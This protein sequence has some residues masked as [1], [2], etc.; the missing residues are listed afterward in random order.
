MA[1]QTWPMINHDPSGAAIAA[2][3]PSF[4]EANV[5]RITQLWEAPN[6]GASFPGS[7][8]APGLDRVLPPISGTIT[9][10]GTFA[11]FCSFNGFAY[12][13]RIETGELVWSFL[14]GSVIWCAPLICP[15]VVI[16]QDLFSA[17][18]TVYA[19]NRITGV[20][21]WTRPAHPQASAAG[22]NAAPILVDGKVLI[23]TFSIEPWLA[24][25]PDRIG[26]VP[27]VLPPYT[28]LGTFVQGIFALDPDTGEEE[29]H[30]FII[31]S[32]D[33]PDI[34]SPALFGNYPGYPPTI[35][36]AFRGSL[37][38]YPFTSR[39]Q[40]G[41]TI[42]GVPFQIQLERTLLQTT[43]LPAGVSVTVTEL[44]GVAKTQVAGA[45]ANAS[46]FS[47]DATTGLLTFHSTAAG[48]TGLSSTYSYEEV[49]FNIYGPSANDNLGL[50][51]FGFG[52][53]GGAVFGP[54]TFDLKNRLVYVSVGVASA[55][56]VINCDAVMAINIDDGS[57]A[58]VRTI[59]TDAINDV[60]VAPRPWGYP[61]AF[62][63]DNKAKY[64]LHR[65]T[66]GAGPVHQAADVTNVVTAADS[67]TWLTVVALAN[68]QRTQHNAHLA[69]VAAHFA[70]DA[71]NPI[72]VPA[73]VTQAVLAGAGG[74]FAPFLGTEP[75]ADRSF[76]VRFEN[77]IAGSVTVVFTIEATVGACVI[78]INGLITRGLAIANVAQ[79]DLQS[80]LI[81]GES[82][83][84]TFNVG[85][86]VTTRLGIPANGDFSTMRNLF[87]LLE[88]VETNFKAHQL[89]TIAHGIADT[90]PANQLNP[91]VSEMQRRDPVFSVP[92]SLTSTADPTDIRDV[93]A[94]GSR[95]GR[96]YI[97][98]ALTGN[99]LNGA[100]GELYRSKAGWIGG[101][102]ISPAVD[103]LAGDLFCA[104]NSAPQQHR[105][106]PLYGNGFA[107]P[108]QGSLA[109]L[110]LT[111][112][113]VSF[114]SSITWEV[115]FTGL[116]ALGPFTGG[117]QRGQSLTSA[118]N[119]GQMVIVNDLVMHV[120]LLDDHLWIH[121]KSDGTVLR[122][123]P[124]RVGIGGHHGGI[125]FTEDK[126]FVGSGINLGFF[127]ATEWAWEDTPPELANN[128]AKAF[129]FGLASAGTNSVS[130]DGSTAIINTRELSSD[131]GDNPRQWVIMLGED[132]PR[133]GG[134]GGQ[135]AYI[136]QLV[137]TLN[138][139]IAGRQYQAEFDWIRGGTLLVTANDVRVSC[140]R[141]NASASSDEF[142]Q[143]SAEIQEE[144]GTVQARSLVQPQRTLLLAA[145][146]QGTSVP[147][148]TV[149]KFANRIIGVQA[150]LV[151]AADFE[152]Q[153]AR[154]DDVTIVG[155]AAFPDQGDFGR[156]DIPLAIDCTR[157]IG[158]ETANGA[159]DD[160]QNVRV[161]FEL[162]LP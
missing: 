124:M 103:N 74:V 156:T 29:W 88:Q 43:G 54:L 4:T 42:P 91:D 71:V 161:T 55:P 25:A 162:D 68:D 116:P 149:P 8:L 112:D 126:F 47:A 49:R 134:G 33:D 127:G 11:F 114:S 60:N 30:H 45:P 72:T 158:A 23:H 63:N 12:C 15:N 139:G 52:P 102:A 46:E 76:D 130:R 150:T 109:R 44:S 31:N 64:N 27:V 133:L 99:V 28:I 21:V 137:G 89:N 35:V 61:L 119:S 24:G 48:E 95:N 56:P 10:D 142:I 87:S 53:A 3:A 13:V 67:T 146:G 117:A 123:M 108:A 121:R 41:L 5:S 81:S 84:Q 143:V 115:P 118:Y 2:D 122:K 90:V 22:P 14:A 138:F 69:D 20:Q 66:V 105:G 100:N 73:A 34:T 7:F 6:V 101:F 80:N 36:G 19:L 113:G 131:G 75:L 40:T 38:G 147:V 135:L 154:N 148:G 140:R 16:I 129:A 1:Q 120:P 77:P 128:F 59:E 111:Y 98:D 83:V 9:T 58:W 96:F 51:R 65:V 155:R 94:C 50:P 106:G 26:G 104:L 141:D 82:R 85:S 107:D 57:R 39:T 159:G 110:H 160:V 152:L 17:P 18:S 136:G 32:D 153:Q 62:A 37:L 92:M 132:M 145:T 86:L 79:I 144:A 125:G 70:A 157:I 78:T 151:A 93:V 97:L